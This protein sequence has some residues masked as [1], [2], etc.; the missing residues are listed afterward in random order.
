MSV[1]G[2]LLLLKELLVSNSFSTVWSCRDVHRCAPGERTIDYNPLAGEL[3]ARVTPGATAKDER[4]YQA[5]YW[6]QLEQI[7]DFISRTL[8]SLFT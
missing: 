8:N 7:L 5:A 1:S 2:P 3:L 4:A 6:M